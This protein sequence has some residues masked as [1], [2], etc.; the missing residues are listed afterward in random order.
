MSYCLYDFRAP[1]QDFEAL[2][3]KALLVPTKYS[4]PCLTQENKSLH[5]TPPSSIDLEWEHEGRKTVLY[6]ILLEMIFLFS[7]CVLN[8]IMCCSIFHY[9]TFKG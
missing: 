4:G 5:S 7:E 6:I 2:D 1:C 3:P 8:H 9:S